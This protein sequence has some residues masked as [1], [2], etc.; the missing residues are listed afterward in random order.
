MKVF[1]PAGRVVNDDGNPFHCV[2]PGAIRN[3]P[4]KYLLV[5]ESNQ[6]GKS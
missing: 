2:S 5:P 4:A 3:R 1:T 6:I